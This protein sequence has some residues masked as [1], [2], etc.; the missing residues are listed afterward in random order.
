MDNFSPHLSSSPTNSISSAT[1]ASNGEAD[2]SYRP[3]YLTPPPFTPA[4]PAPAPKPEKTPSRHLLPIII[5][6]MLALI[7]IACGILAV[8]NFS[9]AN[10]YRRSHQDLTSKVNKFQPIIKELESK[11]GRAINSPADLPDLA[12]SAAHLYLPLWQIKLKLPTDL[13]D[14]TYSFASGSKDLV[15]FSGQPRGVSRKF[16]FADLA[17]NPYGSGCILR[18]PES[19]GLKDAS[20]IN[21]GQLIK[22]IAGYNYFYRAS[23]K[24][25]S[26]QPAEQDLERSVINSVK[27]LIISSLESY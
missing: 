7:A 22:I 10:R 20:G 26:S 9:E 12:L 27:Q 13:D 14:F 25:F 11:T 18:R 21:F 5:F 4:D 19:A 6:S 24:L 1:S 15:C 3:E 17:K 16:A 8:M 23:S 2:P